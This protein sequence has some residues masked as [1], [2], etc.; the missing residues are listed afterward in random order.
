ME[1]VQPNPYGYVLVL[2]EVDPASVTTDVDRVEDIPLRADTPSASAK[3]AAL[4]E[5]LQAARG[6]LAGLDRVR[7]VS[8]FE[9]A[10]FPPERPGRPAPGGSWGRPARYDSVML[11]ET[12][13]PAEAESLLSDPVFGEV[14]AT[15]EGG[16]TYTNVLPVRNVKKVDDVD[17]TKDGVFLFNFFFATDRE[18]LLDIWDYTAGWWLAEGNM[19]NSELMM[20]LGMSDYAIINNARWDDWDDAHPAVHAFRKAG[21]REFVMANLDASG[22]TAMPTLYRLVA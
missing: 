11:I 22:A 8:V 19:L 9:A 17:R 13:S 5:S 6:R 1:L 16:S 7:A 20:P 4:H 14:R 15:V 3:R 21:Y 10:L 12:G 2:A 18:D